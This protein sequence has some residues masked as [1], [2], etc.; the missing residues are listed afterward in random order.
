MKAAYGKK[1][2]EKKRLDSAIS[3][4]M[5]IYLGISVLTLRELWGFGYERNSKYADNLSTLFDDW[6]EFYRQHGTEGRIETVGDVYYAAKR[7]V[8]DLGVLVDEIEKRCAPFVVEKK[9]KYQRGNPESRM[10][11]LK[12][13]D[14][15]MASIWFLTMLWLHEEYEFGAVRLSRYYKGCREMLEG[16]W[17]PYLKCSSEGDSECVAFR[18]KMIADCDS[19][20][21]NIA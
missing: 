6:F 11:F 16:F 21:V 15:S 4:M 3:D 9:E 12:A 5:S 19:I 8:R 10:E 7:D 2:Q 17:I 18:D 14:E 1:K 13:T 20:G